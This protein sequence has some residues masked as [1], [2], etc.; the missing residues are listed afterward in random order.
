MA[1]K[2]MSEHVRGVAVL[3]DENRILL[4]MG[5]ASEPRIRGI[6]SDAQWLDDALR[7][8]TA[9]LLFTDAQ[10][11]ALVS[12]VAQ[13]K[14]V[15][16][17]DKPSEV[18]LNFFLNVDFAFDIIDHMLSDPY[19][20]MAIIDAKERMAFVSPIHEKFFGLKTGEGVG[21]NVKDVIQNTRLHH[22]VRTGVAEVGH[23][24]KIGGTERVVSRHPIRH[25]GK[26]VGAIGRVMF[27]GPQQ[28]DAMARRI[29]ALERE[30]E[31]YRSES[32]ALKRG[33]EFLNAIVGQSPAIQH[34]RNQIR[35]IAALDIPVLIQGES[36][37]GKELVAQA[38][39]KLS[40]RHDARLVTVNAAALPMS[41]V[42]SELFGYE[43]GSFTGADKKGRIGKFE[44]ADKGTIFLDE[45]GDMPLEVQS[46]LLRVLQDR[47]VERVGGDKPRKVDFRLVSATNRDLE[48]FIAQN[49]FRLDLYY[50]ISSV[51]IMMPSLADRLE[52]IP[53]LTAHFL[54]Q[55]AE[56]YGRPAPEVSAEVIDYL[57]DRAWPGNI[58]EL[59]HVIER[60]FIFCENDA[61]KVSDFTDHARANPQE[62]NRREDGGGALRVHLEQ[63]ERQM[64]V[65][66]MVEFGGNKK[67]VAEHLGVS[68]SYLYKK[69]DASE[70]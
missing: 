56:Q 3:S 42:E 68:R 25:D 30:I 8:R 63:V 20:A 61:L 11:M 21:R 54:A 38:L 12:K 47:I 5:L 60:A 10:Y 15:I 34:V 26:V 53:D 28:L 57:M 2:E 51:A 39:H 27:K 49:K 41:L 9:P 29:N 67:K 48:E 36:G 44:L 13:G 14:L 66:A 6:I 31:V 65:A 59:R 22:V 58:R 18:V 35:K 62:P 40:P 4:H 1:K 50:R 19:D 45:I 33:E 17:F 37:T 24:L 7:R 23:I 16:L 69:L 52:D 32:V 64:I 55:L 70:V 46:K 43:A